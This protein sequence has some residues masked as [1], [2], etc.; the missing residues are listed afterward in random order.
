MNL[1]FYTSVTKGLNKKI[2]KF[3]GL[4][5]TFLKVTG[6]KLAAGG[7]GGRGRLLAPPS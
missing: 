5:P 1:K 6:E 3:R 7:G 2:R 4:V